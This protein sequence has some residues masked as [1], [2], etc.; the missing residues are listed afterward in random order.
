[1][2]AQ[3]EQTQSEQTVSVRTAPARKGNKKKSLKRLKEEAERK[4]R[5][6]AR[7]H[8]RTFTHI[9]GSVLLVVFIVSVSVF[10]AQYIVRAALD[11]TGITVESLEY[12]VEIP[13]DAPT[14]DIA[15]I[16]KDAGIIGMPELFC[17]YSRISDKDGKYLRGLFT[18]NSN[19]SYGQ[20]IRILQTPSSVNETVRLRI[21][22]G[23]TAR[24][25]GE[26]LEENLVCRAADF[27]VFYK[28]KMNAYNFEKRLPQNSSKFY[29]LEG[30]LFPDTYE[31]YVVNEMEHSEDFDTLK[32]AEIAA[33]TIYSNTQERI[34]PEMY[35]RINEM[36]LTLDQFMTLASM[37]QKEA[38]SV[39]DMYL[40][41]A[42]F[43]NRL[44]NPM[45][46]PHLQSDVTI[47]YA[48]ENIKPYINGENAAFYDGVVKAYNS[49]ESE[50]LPPGPICN[51]GKEAMDA[52]ISAPATNETLA[53]IGK[54]YYYF[55]ANVETLEMFFAET[56]YE[57][58]QNLRLAGLDAD[59]E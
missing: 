11:F 13:G 28:N 22:E 49:Y 38:G 47:I 51:P 2:Q 4:R 19:M 37:T 44:N 40:V 20:I 41:A 26:L 34:T 33:K 43:V 59:D 10:L 21:T 30:Y 57:H 45:E 29:Q 48:E 54:K 25:I 27:E 23:M 1:E 5:R 39:D 46:F 56:L 8:V 12:T 18:L 31:F 42:V 53:E 35:K 52:V 58:E 6:R 24:E 55:C 9:F 7:E 50:G 3:S 17:L 36:G 32:Y 14:E 15:E 16:L